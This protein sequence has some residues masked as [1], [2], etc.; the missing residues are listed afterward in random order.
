MEWCRDAEPGNS[1][2]VPASPLVPVLFLSPALKA[3]LGHPLTKQGFSTFFPEDATKIV[4]FVMCLC[5]NVYTCLLACVCVAKYAYVSVCMCVFMQSVFLY[6]WNIAP[7]PFVPLEFSS[8]LIFFEEKRLTGTSPSFCR[9]AAMSLHNVCL[10]LNDCEKL[11]RDRHLLVEIFALQCFS[12][13]Y[14]QTEYQ[15][16][17]FC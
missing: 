11:S 2:F 10:L 7:F 12:A 17:R 5:V 15:Q 16:E 14:S 6:C 13:L 3:R 1:S 9:G 8:T 4:L